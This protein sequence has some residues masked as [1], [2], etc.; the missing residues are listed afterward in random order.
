MLESEFY[1]FMNWGNVLIGAVML[2]LSQTFNPSRSLVGEFADQHAVIHCSSRV[3][4]LIATFYPCIMLIKFP[5]SF[6]EQQ[7]EQL[8]GS[9]TLSKS[10]LAYMSPHLGVL[11]NIPFPIPF[12]ICV[13]IFQYFIASDMMNHRVDRHRGTGRTRVL[14]RRGMWCRMGLINWKG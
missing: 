4:L 2:Q 6:E 5:H 1:L 10:Q 11:N 12:K 3:H 7:I 9:H 14:V 13:S 8:I